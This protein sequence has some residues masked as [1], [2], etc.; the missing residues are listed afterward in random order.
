[1]REICTTRHNRE[2]E[3]MTT[4]GTGIARVMMWSGFFWAGFALGA[5]IG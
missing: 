3:S 1:M 4:P 2:G 5:W